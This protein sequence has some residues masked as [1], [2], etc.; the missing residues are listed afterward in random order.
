MWNTSAFPITSLSISEGLAFKEWLMDWIIRLTIPSNHQDRFF[1]F[2]ATLW[3]IWKLRNQQVFSD[4]PFLSNAALALA[5]DSALWFKRS[6]LWAER[7]R[8]KLQGA[9]QCRRR[10]HL[11]SS[12]TLHCS[13]SSPPAGNQYPCG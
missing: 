12:H 10:H 7:E 13:H 8:L 2:V 3:A 11:F 4:T 5:T 9:P 1:Q 6:S